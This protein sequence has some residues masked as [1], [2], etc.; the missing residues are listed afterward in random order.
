MKPPHPPPR[1][2]LCSPMIKAFCLVA[3]GSTAHSSG[4]RSGSPAT[5]PREGSGGAVTTPETDF[6]NFSFRCA[7]FGRG[8]LSSG[9]ALF[10]LS[11]RARHVST[12]RP[13]TCW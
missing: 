1:P 3:A 8:R 13:C 10:P 7:L 12:V 5:P 6:H 2:T 9:D 11:L 4:S